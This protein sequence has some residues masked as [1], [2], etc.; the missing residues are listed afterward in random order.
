[1]HFFLSFMCSC[2]QFDFNMLECNYWIKDDL[3]R[4]KQDDPHSKYICSKCIDRLEEFHAYSCEVSANQEILQFSAANSI[5]ISNEKCRIVQLHEYVVTLQST[6]QNHTA[7]IDLNQ[8]LPVVDENTPIADLAMTMDNNVEIHKVEEVVTDEP[9]TIELN[10]VS[11][12]IAQVKVETTDNPIIRKS[13]RLSRP[14]STKKVKQKLKVPML[15]KMNK[16]EESDIETVQ[17][18]DDIV[19]DNNDVYDSDGTVDL[20]ECEDDKFNVPTNCDVFLADEKFAGFPKVIIENS[21]LIFRG[22]KLLDLLS[23]FYR[24]ECDICT[25]N[26]HPNQAK[27]SRISTLCDH[28]N[29]VHSIKGYVICCGLRLIKPRAMAMHMARHLQP[30]AFKCPTCEKMMTCP[31]ILQYHIQNHLPEK[32]RPLACPMCPRKFSYSSALVA[33]AISHQPENERAAHICDECGK[34]FS[35]PGRLSSHINVAHINHAADYICH[36]CAKQFSCRSNL[37]YHL[38]THQPK[39]HQVQCETCGKWLKNKLCLRKHMV[40]HSMVRFNCEMCDYSALNRQ[41]LRNHIKVQHSDI[42]PFSCQYCGKT[43]KLRNTLLNHLVQ[44]TGIRKFFCE[45]CGRTFASSGNYYS[46]RKRMHPQEL[47]AV[48]EKKEEEERQLREKVFENRLKEEK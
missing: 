23:K 4:V 19:D 29:E 1:M 16:V 22:K 28:Y 27:Y 15:K 8:F 48:K 37:T 36:I 10:D 6:G 14:K 20:N 32:E 25:E 31:K 13:K 43:F 33:H 3:L 44:H 5:I 7:T 30:D 9:E 26:Q 38:T 35:S 11:E 17:S 21:K 24:L 45:F 34:S 40:Q 18:K 39:I 46:H 42:K 2:L 47:A 12:Q 41:C